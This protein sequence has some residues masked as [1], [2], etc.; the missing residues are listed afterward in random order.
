MHSKHYYFITNVKIILVLLYLI[1]T[2]I[3]GYKKIGVPT[4]SNFWVRHC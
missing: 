3:L 4:M 1:A 2:Y